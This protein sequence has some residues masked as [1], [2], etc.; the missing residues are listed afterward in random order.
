MTVASDLEPLDTPAVLED[1]HPDGIRT[2]EVAAGAGYCVEIHPG[3]L[4]DTANLAERLTRLLDLDAARRV[5]IISDSNVAPL[6]AEKVKAALDSVDT[7]THAGT[8]VIPAGEGSKTPAML[9]DVLEQMAAQELTRR[10]AVIALGGG[11]TGDLAGL[12][13]ALYMRGIAC[14]QIPTSLLAMVD[15][16]VGG[17]TAVDLK[18]GK[19][20]MGAFSQPVGVLIDPEV[21]ATLPA[22]EVSCGWGEIIKYAGLNE[23]VRTLVD[24]TL[25]ADRAKEEDATVPL[26]N[27]DLIAHSIDVKRRI[28]SEDERESGARRL[29]NYGHTVGHAVESAAQWKLSHGASVG[30]GMSIL[31]RAEVASG[32]VPEA[33]LTWLET[34]LARAGLSATIPEELLSDKTLDFSPEALL[35][36]ARHDKKAASGGV[37]LVVPS[38]MEGCRIERVSW[39]ELLKRIR[40]GL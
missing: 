18:A 7:S 12:A 27:V 36:I 10:D 20:L 4:S 1:A 35:A 16:S 32:R 38:G 19:N 17:K 37:A 22:R 26:P 9:V 14:L 21:L 29:L 8:I 33:R 11:V 34:M 2:I 5:V 24:R 6:Y 39:D 30:I 28:V 15:S 25:V 40:V 31:M 13:A 3:L 23:S